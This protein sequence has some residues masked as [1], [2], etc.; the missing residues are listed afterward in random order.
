MQ[1][2]VAQGNAPTEPGSEEGS[3]YRNEGYASADGNLKEKSEKERK[4]RVAKHRLTSSVTLRPKSARWAA[5]A[6]EN[7]LLNG[8]I[9]PA[10]EEMPHWAGGLI[11]AVQGGETSS[12]RAL[13]VLTRMCSREGARALLRRGIIR[14]L[15]STV[16]SDPEE[17]NEEEALQALLS[18]SDISGQRFVSRAVGE[19]EGAR[20]L[21]VRGMR[22]GDS[23]ACHMALRAAK[24][25]PERL[26]LE[27]GFVAALCSLVTPR[28]ELEVDDSRRTLAVEAL[29]LLTSG[30]IRARNA[31]SSRGGAEAFVIA[32]R[33]SIGSGEL[34]GLNRL[35][36]TSC[37]GAAYRWQYLEAA[38][39]LELARDL[40]FTGNGP[41]HKFSQALLSHASTA[42]ERH[43]EA[44]VK[45]GLV[46]KLVLKI[47]WNETTRQVAAWGKPVLAGLLGE[48]AASDDVRRATRL[49][50]LE[51]VAHGENVLSG[52][53]VKCGKDISD[54]LTLCLSTDDWIEAELACKG[55]LHLVCGK[56]A[57]R[58][59]FVEKT[60]THQ[61]VPWAR[62]GMPGAAKAIMELA[63]GGEDGHS[64]A[65]R[66]LVTE[67]V[68]KA[69]LDGAEKCDECEEA[70]AALAQKK[71]GEQALAATLAKASSTRM[72]R[73]ALE[74]SV[75]AT[76]ERAMEAMLD[77]PEVIQ[78]LV[79]AAGQ[80]KEPDAARVL[81]NL[82]IS[83]VGPARGA[84][85]IVEHSKLRNLFEWEVS[86]ETS[87]ALSYEGEPVDKEQKEEL[88][89]ARSEVIR[90]VAEHGNQDTKTAI[91]EQ[92]IAELLAAMGPMKVNA[93][94][95][96]L[97]ADYKPCSVLAER[98]K[99]PPPWGPL[100]ALAAME[101][102]HMESSKEGLVSG[103]A[104][105]TFAASLSS[106]SGKTAAI[107]AS[108]ARIVMAGPSRSAT[109][110]KRETRL[111]MAEQSGLVKALAKRAVGTGG[112]ACSE[113]ALALAEWTKGEGAHAESRR[114]LLLRD[115]TLSRV[116]RLAR[117]SN[118][119]AQAC[120][121]VAKECLSSSA[122]GR[123][124]ARALVSS[125]YAS[126]TDVSVAAEHLADAA[127][128]AGKLL[129]DK[130]AERWRGAAVA[131]G[132]GGAAAKVL[133]AAGRGETPEH[134]GEAA[135]RAIH[136]LIAGTPG[137]RKGSPCRGE[138]RRA[139]VMAREGAIEALSRVTYHHYHQATL[140]FPAIQYW[141]LP[142]LDGVRWARRT[143]SY[144]ESP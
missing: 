117:G 98:L 107:A 126:W 92:G 21:M 67:A 106:S 74:W 62:E 134:T 114:M 110:K 46:G 97:L 36:S 6:V 142:A 115:G 12:L 132:A 128:L 64:V 20:M 85:R 103:G 23:C 55:V 112:E 133:A 109:A 87:Y 51:A 73:R 99:A 24:E 101:G 1:A 122:T 136:F 68:H 88:E 37:P 27:E 34:K 42:G 90:S 139:E 17:K 84:E 58:A 137:P 108:L 4:Q 65:R 54:A 56:D 76:W 143:Y 61:L 40:V 66:E 43:A 32:I 118:P 18:L 48:V 83:E 19:D 22:R 11:S 10:E 121:L 25:V 140:S 39:A 15:G 138:A 131:A 80:N 44:S 111:Q 129:N 29:S 78:G 50:A 69:L 53:E 120:T 105:E 125:L 95:S 28:T 104:L 47:G 86:H 94:L 60:V 2:K 144:P 81:C 7:G 14:V 8:D 5:E 31:I 141:A 127:Q 38:G 71:G 130:E 45:V 70:L 135:A 16:S 9:D 41:W 96:A 63:A 33:H 77:Q 100:A 57:K 26:A 3:G 13:V 79:N 91:V 119:R 124:F 35:A 72:W 123:G 102:C 82:A 113:S 52:E 30:S 75:R 89:W 116:I 49:W 59:M 93:T